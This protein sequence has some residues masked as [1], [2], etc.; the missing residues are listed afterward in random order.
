MKDKTYESEK[1]RM[2]NIAANHVMNSKGFW[3]EGYDESSLPDFLLLW[4]ERPGYSRFGSIYEMCEPE[5]FFVLLFRNEKLRNT[6]SIKE[7]KAM[8]TKFS[9]ECDEAKE[10]A[11]AKTSSRVC[12]V[13]DSIG[14]NR[15][16]ERSMSMTKEEIV[17][18]MEYVRNSEWINYI[19]QTV[20][21]IQQMLMSKAS[22]ESA[23]SMV[24]DTISDCEIRQKYFEDS[25][26]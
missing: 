24:R 21:E 1:S 23:D 12:E 14:F 5:A 3:E 9:M 6:K 4:N 7:L 19:E 10:A 11:M 25:I 26:L 13:L 15:S 18:V 22:P 20:E 16:Y 8:A 17:D 2:E